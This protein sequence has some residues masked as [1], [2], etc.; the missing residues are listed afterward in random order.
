MT[1]AAMP[2]GNDTM[3]YVVDSA[4]PAHAPAADMA[5]LAEMIRTLMEVEARR[6][7]RVRLGGNLF[8]VVVTSSG[9]Q[10]RSAAVFMDSVQGGCG[11][12]IEDPDSG[13]FYWLVPPGS[14]AQWEPHR[15]AVCLGAPHTIT[16]PSLDR[17]VPPG[18]YWFRPSASDRLVPTG[19]L[20][21]ALARF[22]PEPTPHA[23]LPFAVALQ[24]VRELP[25]TTGVAP[26][27]ATS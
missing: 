8:D 15:H 1:A 18:S 5:D 10:A 26:A 7:T 14:A 12:V 24:A 6:D 23:A 2:T 4:G 25:R 27:A 19:P 20:R 11:P 16:L 3:Q 17:R 9:L 21:E 13:W 22:R